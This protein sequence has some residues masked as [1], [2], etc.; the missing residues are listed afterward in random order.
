MV[1]NST[2]YIIFL[3]YLILF[4]PILCLPLSHHIVYSNPGMTYGR[5]FDHTHSLYSK[6]TRQSIDALKTY[7]KVEFLFKYRL[8]IILQPLI[9]VMCPLTLLLSY[10]ITPLFI[11]IYLPYSLPP[12]LTQPLNHPFIF[13]TI[14]L[15]H[16]L[17]SSLTHLLITIYLPH[18]L[19]PSLPLFLSQPPIHS[20]P[21]IYPIYVPHSLPL[22]LSH[23]FIHHHLCTLGRCMQRGLGPGRQAKESLQHTLAE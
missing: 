10:S 3:L 21:S 19:P 13:I 16:S 22:F 20:Q 9:N 8:S 6:L 4:N 23:L 7:F 2:Y 1:V 5:Q 15:S 14:Y 17:P 11:T 18:S 12:S